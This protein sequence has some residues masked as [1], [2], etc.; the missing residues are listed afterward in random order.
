[1]TVPVR[2]GTNHG[3]LVKDSG[4]YDKWGCGNRPPDLTGHV[5]ERP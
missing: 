2:V 5:A 3:D 1:M 4:R